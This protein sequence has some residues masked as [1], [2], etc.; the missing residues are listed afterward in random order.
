MKNGH[1][2]S[3]A[4][5]DDAALLAGAPTLT[6]K[7]RAFAPSIVCFISKKAFGACFGHKP[8]SYGRQAVQIAESEV[9]VVPSPS[10]RVSGHRLFDG[11]TRLDWFGLLA[12]SV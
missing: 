11:R 7:V 5:L 1:R 2:S 12:Q 6:E 10:G 9:W 4:L 3:D 8:S